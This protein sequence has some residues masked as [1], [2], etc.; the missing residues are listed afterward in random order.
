MNTWIKQKN[1]KI[2]RSFFEQKIPIA[3]IVEMS[4][5]F[6]GADVVCLRT[7]KREA[8]PSAQLIG[9]LKRRHFCRNL[10]AI[11]DNCFWLHRIKYCFNFLVFKS[12]HFIKVYNSYSQNQTI[13]FKV[14]ALRSSN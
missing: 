11:Q 5:G 10:N 3:K 4:C 2:S 14:T 6:R 8:P 7:E 13:A 1:E 9:S 12:L